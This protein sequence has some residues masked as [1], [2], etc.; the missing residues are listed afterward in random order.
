MEF[1]ADLKYTDNDEWVRVEG[2]IGTVGI[3]DY[4]QDQL[5]DIVFVEISSEVGDK[6]EKDAALGEVESVKAAAFIYMPITGV[7]TEINANLADTPELINADPYG[8]AWMIKFEITN[9]VELDDLLDAAAY[10]K[11]CQEREH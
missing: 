10:E 8:E 11:Y 6:L 4:A 5:S 1:P 2:D 7:I 9:P 3:T